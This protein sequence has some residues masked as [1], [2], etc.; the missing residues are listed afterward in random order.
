MSIEEI[1]KLKK[2]DLVE[3]ISGASNKHE[4]HELLEDAIIYDDLDFPCKLIMDN[5][6]CKVDIL[7]V[8]VGKKAIKLAVGYEKAK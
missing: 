2:G 3:V 1:K 4:V 5:L 6:E 7:G 8:P